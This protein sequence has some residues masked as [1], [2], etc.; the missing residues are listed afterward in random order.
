MNDAS[1][2]PLSHEQV[3]KVWSQTML[4]HFRGMSRQQQLAAVKVGD[5]DHWTD[6]ERAKALDLLGADKT[7]DDPATNPTTALFEP[8]LK[9]LAPLNLQPTKLD[10]VLLITLGGWISLLALAWLSTLGGLDQ[11]ITGGA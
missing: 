1:L 8:A 5:L 11:L 9:P 2:D 7:T 6:E 4:K 10:T 3:H